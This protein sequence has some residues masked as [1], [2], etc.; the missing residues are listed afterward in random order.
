[1]YT[2]LITNNILIHE[3]INQFFVATTAKLDYPIKPRS[4]SQNP[5]L[6]GEEPF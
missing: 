2:L 3:L 1:M 6:C 4:L 5:P